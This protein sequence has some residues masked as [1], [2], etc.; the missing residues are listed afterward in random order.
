[1]KTYEKELQNYKR[2]KNELMTLQNEKNQLLSDKL[3]K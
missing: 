3:V 1:M 2:V